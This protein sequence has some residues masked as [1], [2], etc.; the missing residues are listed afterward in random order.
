[1]ALLDVKTTNELPEA[2]T[3]AELYNHKERSFTDAATKKAIGF[4]R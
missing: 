1:M 4:N 2:R 3:L